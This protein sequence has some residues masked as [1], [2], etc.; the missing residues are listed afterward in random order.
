MEIDRD[1]MMPIFLGESEDNLAEIEE[2]LLELEAAPDDR[3]AIARLFR[4]AHTL[5]GNAESLGVGA[6][7]TCAHAL[8]SVLDAVRR[9]SLAVSAALVS[10][11]LDAHDALRAML[12]VVAKGESARIDEHEAL[13]RALAKAA[14]EGI[15]TRLRTS[16]SPGPDGG[17]RG[18]GSRSKTLRVALATLDRILASTGELSIAR[19]RLHTAL[20][21]GPVSGSVADALEESDRLLAELHE[22]AMRLRLVP[23]GPMLRQQ[24][25]IVRDLAASTGK[26]ARLVIEGDDVEVD[27]AVAHELRDPILH[28]VRNAIDHAIEP[29]GDRID[30]GKDPVGTVRISA[31]RETGCLVVRISDDGAG[32][33]RARIAERAVE[34]GLIPAGATPSDREIDALVFAPGFSTAREVTELSGR[35]V[36][37]DVVARNV[38]A[39][40]GTIAIESEPGRGATVTLRVPL[41]LAIISGFAVAAA[42]ET[43]VLPLDSVRECIDLRGVERREPAGVIL[44]RGDPLPYLRLREIFALPGAAPRCESVVVVEHEG[45]RAGIAVDALCGER[46]AVV[47]P[48]GCLFESC[49]GVAGSTILGDGRV[50]LILD[51]ASILERAAAAQSRRAERGAPS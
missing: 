33:D 29:P 44:L 20:G 31:R 21:R 51:V 16:S 30:R 23:L 35:G 50:A 32:F 13:L 22:H 25:R 1:A 47:K 18:R 14:E 34:A 10:L 6:M 27:T 7:A 9:R 43:F 45:R 8:E 48:M 42:D 38:A 19:G 2:T 49:A 24:A 39:M 41:T 5:K 40:K 36:G 4:A 37:M 11:L 26:L 3:E 28:M 17:D 15:V 12:A 46:Q